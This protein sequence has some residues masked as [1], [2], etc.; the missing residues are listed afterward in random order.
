ME[1]GADERHADRQR[2]PPLALRTR[3][4]DPGG[5]GAG[6]RRDPADDH[7]VGGGAV[8]AVAGA[9]VPDRARVRGRAGGGVP[10]GIDMRQL[11]LSAAVVAVVLFAAAVA[12][13]GAALDG[14]LQA[15]H[16][17]GLMGARGMPKGLGSAEPT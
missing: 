17:V 1:A 14:Y 16:S 10:V 11:P 5:A 13:F 7:R 2:D 3:R 6:L 4:D 12:G 9:G 8:C 15:I